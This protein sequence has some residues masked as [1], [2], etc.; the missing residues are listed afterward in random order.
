MHRPPFPYPLRN[1]SAV[2]ACSPAKTQTFVTAL[3]ALGANVRA[4]EMI[5]TCEISD[6][7]ALD[8]AIQSLDGYDWIIFTSSYGVQFFSRRM[9]VLGRHLTAQRHGRICAVGPATARTLQENGW[10]VDLIPRDFV[11]EGILQALAELHGGL[12]G[13]AGKRI[14]LPRAKEA[15]DV[16]PN[17]LSA[18]AATV[19]VVPCYETVPGEIDKTTLEDIRSGVPDLLL[20]TSSSTIT[21]FVNTLGEEIGRKILQQATVAVL[22]PITAGTAAKFG[23]KVEILPDEN[24][25]ASLIE[26]IRRHYQSIS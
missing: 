6:K 15:R 10:T 20:F 21:S 17:A 8:A 13:L 12:A 9:V 18:A 25:A 3:E 16:L 22:G 11:A 1:K 23:K 5:R 4:I 7:R 2:V 24:T 26:A 14:L 19:D